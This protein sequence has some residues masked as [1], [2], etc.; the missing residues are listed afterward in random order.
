MQS[1]SR[2]RAPGASL[3]P[4][5]PRPRRRSAQRRSSRGGG[6]APRPSGVSRCRHGPRPGRVPH[7]R[8]PTAAGPPRCRGP[9]R[10]WC[11]RYRPA[12]DD[13]GDHA[14]R[15]V[16]RVRALDHRSPRARRAPWHHPPWTRH[17]R[18]DDRGHERR[19]ASAA[20][21]AAPP[22]GPM[23]AYVPPS[24]SRG[25]VAPRRVIP[26]AREVDRRQ[27]RVH[28][29]AAWPIH[30]R[31]A[32]PPRADGEPVEGRAPAARR[33]G[34]RRA[35]SDGARPPP[36]RLVPRAVPAPHRIPSP[37]R[38][39]RRRSPGPESRGAISIPR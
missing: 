18:R 19:R 17:S 10:W 37:I 16:A 6:F 14:I 23:R 24:S 29:G 31:P 21:P 26:A 1:V 28:R 11:R 27:R 5:A 25:F 7:E 3:V 38:L 34:A 22:A 9:S 8:R 32:V 4:R 33:R 35:R 39:W 20:V 13:V 15:G 2:A 12:P 30:E 36:P